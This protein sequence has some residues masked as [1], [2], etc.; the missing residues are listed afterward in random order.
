MPKMN[1]IEMIKEIRNLDNKIPIVLVTG[2]RSL[3]VLVEAINLKIS[4]FLQKP[5]SL[6]DLNAKIEEISKIKQLKK[7]LHL[8]NSLLEQYKHVVDESAIVSKTDLDGVITYVNNQFC[9]ISGY[10][11]EE[12]I[13]EK[14]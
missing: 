3:D 5:M 10:D 7:E 13:R 12:L 11:E 1:G 2:L 14:T 4:Q 8:N 6:S 9:Q